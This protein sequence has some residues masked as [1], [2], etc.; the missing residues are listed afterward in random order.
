MSDEN[1]QNLRSYDWASGDGR[2]GVTVEFE[3]FGFEVE[4]DVPEDGLVSLHVERAVQTPE[5]ED[6]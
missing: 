2:R 6:R 5:G 3:A 1:A 4:L